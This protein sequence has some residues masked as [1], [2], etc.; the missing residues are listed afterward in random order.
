MDTADYDDPEV[1]QAWCARQ[2][3]AVADYLARENLVHGRV[4]EWP[5]WHVAPLVSVWAIESKARPGWVGWWVLAGY[6]P[7]DYVSAGAIRHPRHALAAIAARWQRYVA[8]VRAGATPDDITIGDDSVS[9]GELLPLL[10]TR[11]AL[12]TEWAGDDALWEGT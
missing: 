4:G 10:E 5:A 11:A 3:S 8:D 7:T 2:R 6:L 9:P 12:L 1:E